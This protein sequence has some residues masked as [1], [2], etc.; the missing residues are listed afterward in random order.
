M[1]K[2]KGCEME[3]EWEMELASA[4]ASTLAL[5]SL[6]GIRRPSDRSVITHGAS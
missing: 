1:E 6:L 3:L 2:E 4:R 5:A